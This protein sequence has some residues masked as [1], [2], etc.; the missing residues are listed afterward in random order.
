MRRT[1]SHVR[2]AGDLLPTA[3]RSLGVQS[4]RITRRI[5]EAWGRAADPAWLADA[6]PSSLVGGALEIGVS[7]SSLREELAQ[8]HGARLL[9]VLRAALPDL[10]LTSVRFTAAP[11]QRVR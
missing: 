4:K 6:R 11:P 9:V 8:F 3:L 1:R 5:E 10:G 2:R 7:S